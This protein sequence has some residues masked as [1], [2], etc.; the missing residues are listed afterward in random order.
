MRKLIITSLTLIVTIFSYSQEKIKLP[1]IE[2]KAKLLEEI[3]LT[4]DQVIQFKELSTVGLDK[5]RVVETL[6]EVQ[7]ILGKKAIVVPVSYN[8]ISPLHRGTV[9]RA[10]K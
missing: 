7:K 10:Y 4:K 3:D 5:L 9:I 2:E 8:V 1:Q 6:W